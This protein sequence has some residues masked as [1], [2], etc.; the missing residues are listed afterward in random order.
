MVPEESESRERAALAVELPAFPQMKQ[1]ADQNRQTPNRSEQDLSICPRLGRGA[2]PDRS[3][4]PLNVNRPSST[5]FTTNPPTRAPHA[6]P[7]K[8]MISLV[9]STIPPSSTCAHLR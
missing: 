1:P 2:A 6:S 7:A 9:F 3:R 5:F 4:L 8:C